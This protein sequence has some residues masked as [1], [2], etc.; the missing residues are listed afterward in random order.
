VKSK[1][2]L[3]PAGE[4]RL[5][6]T[7]FADVTSLEKALKEAQSFL[8]GNVNAYVVQ[9]EDWRYVYASD[10]FLKLIGTQDVSSIPDESL[11][12]PQLKELELIKLRDDWLAV[13]FGVLAEY[14]DIL[15]LRCMTGEI[16]QVK[17]FARKI[18]RQSGAGFLTV[19]GYE[20]QT[21]LQRALNAANT[22]LESQ[23]TAFVIQNEDFSYYYVSNEFLRLCDVS[24]VEEIGDSAKGFW[25]NKDEAYIRTNRERLSSIPTGHINEENEPFIFVKSSGARL[26]FNVKSKWI[27]NPA[28]VGRL[29]IT[30]FEDVTAIEE[31]RAQLDHL[32]KTAELYLE[33]GI[34]A[35]GI[36]NDNF[37]HLYLS[38]AFI[39]LT[40]YTVDTMPNHKDFY[41]DYDEINAKRRR[42]ELVKAPNGKIVHS[43]THKVRTKDGNILW[44]SRSARWFKGISGERLLMVSFEDHTALT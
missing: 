6:I 35:Y 12:F 24:T 14:P 32:K 30:A 43:G 36:Q 7:S 20:D 28:G 8:E 25:A 42:E 23:M 5:L 10:Q 33:S 15:S 16:K 3:N 41:P 22:F 21:E 27:L 34:N 37:E 40:G 44:L 39:N 9:D 31:Q 1:W 26:S 29:L 2:I 19:V 17:R 18:K 4:G 11:L 38:K 13:D